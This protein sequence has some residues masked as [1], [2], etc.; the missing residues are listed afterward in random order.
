MGWDGKLGPE[1]L[2]IAPQSG[3]EL[4]AE[5][6]ADEVEGSEGRGREEGRW[7]RRED[8]AAREV[9]QDLGEG[10]DA[11]DECA[12][13]T[14]GLAEGAY[15]DIRGDSQVCAES[16]SVGSHDAKRVSLVDVEGGIVVPGEPEELG[17]GRDVGVHAEEGL[18]NE[19]SSSSGW[20]VAAKEARGGVKVEVRVDSQL[21]PGQAA[22]IDDGGMDG[23]IGDEEV[24]RTGKGGDG[25]EIGLVARWEEEGGLGLDEV[26]EGSFELGMVWEI[27]G[28]KP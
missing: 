25:T 22:G 20:A 4:V 28:D 16:P 26:G 13:D 10:L 23:A 8:E 7:C 11:C 24:V 2:D 18:G 12:R 27:A 21:G 19:E 3:A 15:Q 17:E 9:L 14:K 6:R 1:L 5:G